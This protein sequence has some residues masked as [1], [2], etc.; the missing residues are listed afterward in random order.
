M[1]AKNGGDKG[2][3]FEAYGF[4]RARFLNCVDYSFALIPIFS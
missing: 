4:E 1:V 2:R 3:V